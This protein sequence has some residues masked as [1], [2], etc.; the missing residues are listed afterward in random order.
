MVHKFVPQVWGFV[1]LGHV[2]SP[3]TPIKPKVLEVG[4]TTDKCT[5][6][7]IM[8]WHIRLSMCTVQV[9]YLVLVWT[10][11]GQCE[12]V[13]GVAA[14]GT[15]YSLTSLVPRPFLAQTTV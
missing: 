10:G 9:W 12:S 1:P 5:Y 14:E 11:M 6:I 7:I 3:P 15:V 8:L 4:H 2:N 13:R